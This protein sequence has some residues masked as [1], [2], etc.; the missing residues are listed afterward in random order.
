MCSCVLV[1]V[2]TWCFYQ[3]VYVVTLTSRC[4]RWKPQTLSV[5]K[6]TLC[7]HVCV[8]V[9]IFVIFVLFTLQLKT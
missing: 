1:A 9:D 3:L 7:V 4:A 6:P 8:L 5:E 2:V